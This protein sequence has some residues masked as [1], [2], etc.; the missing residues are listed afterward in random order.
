MKKTTVTELYK[1]Q[2]EKTEAELASARAELGKKTDA[3][4]R[5]RELIRQNEQGLGILIPSTMF[6]IYDICCD[7]LTV[8]K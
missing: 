3:L 1:T 2:K 8:T 4:V 7:A 5:I 6:E